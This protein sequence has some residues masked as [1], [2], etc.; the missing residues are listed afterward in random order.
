MTRAIRSRT[1]LVAAA[2]AS[3]A[4]TGTLVAP[5][6]GASAPVRQCK[7]AQLQLKFVDFQAAT[8]HRFID[9]AFNNAGKVKCSLRGYPSGALLDQ[10]GNAIT[11]SPAIVT[12]WPLSLLRTVVLS[13]GQRA[14]F[15][16]HWVAGAFCPGR[17][18]TFYGLRVAPP[19]DSS[20]LPWHRGMTLAC[21]YSAMVSAV[22][23]DLFPF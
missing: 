16:F 23:P 2:V 9:Y 14:F 7:T 21:D 6:L 5:A 10:H 13:P 15:T 8:G 18:F 3:I 19:H 20:G 22:R 1:L 4:A 12:G 17:T 11:A